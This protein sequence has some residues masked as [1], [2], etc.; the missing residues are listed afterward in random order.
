VFFEGIRSE[1]QLLALA[2]DRLSVR[3]YLGY[4]LDESLPN[5]SSLTRIRDRY[6]IDVFR[7]FFGCIAEQC[8]KAGLVWG[9]ERYID[10]TKVEANADPD[11]LVPCF[12]VETHLDRL[13]AAPS[14]IALDGALTVDSVD[15][16]ALARRPIPFPARISPDRD[17]TCIAR[18]N[19]IAE[20]GHPDC[21]IVSGLYQRTTDFR[22]STTDPD[23]SPLPLGVVVGS[24]GASMRTNSTGCVTTKTPSRTR[25][26]SGNGRFGSSRSLLKRSS[27]TD[28]GGSSTGTREGQR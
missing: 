1:R 22:V 25:K 8:Q 19:W 4:D 28:S 16:A 15:E 7:R 11:S 20:L 18:H 3:W 10:V 23:S 13:F 17:G 9:R 21:T 27:G 2:T 5:H 26:H 24:G 6:G 12:A 14:A